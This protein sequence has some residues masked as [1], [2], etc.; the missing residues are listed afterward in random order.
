MPMK[1]LELL[2]KLSATPE[3]IEM[4]DAMPASFT[5]AAWIVEWPSS[6]AIRKCGL[7]P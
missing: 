2:R 5:G 1:R 7:E 6:A 4:L 3:G